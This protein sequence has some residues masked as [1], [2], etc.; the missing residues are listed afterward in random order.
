MA[1]GP[2]A[3]VVTDKGEVLARDEDLG[4]LL[5]LIHVDYAWAVGRVH[6]GG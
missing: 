2:R 6:S 5:K 1:H 3:G 4:G